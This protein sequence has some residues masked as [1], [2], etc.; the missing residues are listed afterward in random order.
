MN[1]LNKLER[2]F[3]RYAIRGLSKYLIALYIVGAILSVSSRFTHFDFY[4]SFL[5]LN[6]HL[7]MQGQVWR[8]FT[9]LMATPTDNLIFLILVLLCYY[10][11]CRELEYIWGDFKFNLYILTG[12]VG[13]I[14]ASFILYFVTM[15]PYIYMDTFYLNLSIM[16]AYC[17]SFPE[18]RFYFYGIIPIKAKWLGILEG[19]FLAYNFFVGGIVTKVAIVVSLMNF[20]LFFFGTRNYHKYSPKQARRRNTYIKEVRTSTNM[21]RHR[22]HVCGRTELDDPNL[23]FRY[24]SKCEGNYEYCSAHLYTHVHIRQ[25]SQDELTD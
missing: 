17:A 10:S 22:C 24:C 4:G 25:N 19:I 16:L 23:E 14:I 11:L 12:A 15:I 18:A 5:A 7:V 8:L 2:K 1:F 6:P 13:T 20:L 21:T 3:G 9:F